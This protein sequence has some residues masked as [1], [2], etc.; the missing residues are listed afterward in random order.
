METTHATQYEAI[1]AGMKPV[2]FARL[3][4]T[5]LSL[6]LSSLHKIGAMIEHGVT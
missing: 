3:S 1:Q 2:S 6:Q 5:A 4:P